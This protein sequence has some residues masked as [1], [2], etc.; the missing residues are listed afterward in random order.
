[1]G[2][3]STGFDGWPID[4]H[5]AYWRHRAHARTANVATPIKGTEETVRALTREDV[6]RHHRGLIAPGN[7]VIAAVSDLPVEELAG[8]LTESLGSWAPRPV[9]APLERTALPALEAKR[10]DVARKSDQANVYLGHRGV[11]RDDPEYY[12]LLVMDYVLGMG[13]GFTDRLSRTVRD[14]DGLAYSVYA[15][16]SSTAGVDVGT[17]Y[18][19]VGTSAR[20]RDRAIAGIVT[21]IERIRKAAVDPEELANAKAYLT[22]SFVFGYETAEQIASRLVR[23]HRYG[24]GFDYPARF[25]ERVNA[26]TAEDVLRVAK[27]HLHPDKLV[28][29]SVGPK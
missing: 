1:M 16:I 24:L 17:F 14:R 23:I 10:I 29:A 28:I 3:S 13:P 2:R 6:L 4:C 26:V 18:A 20:Q 11:R 19:Y 15:T 22:G 21:E 9:A 25:A 12:P 27:K 7:T 8:L 5:C